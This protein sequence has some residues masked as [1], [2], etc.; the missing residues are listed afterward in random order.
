MSKR[1]KVRPPTKTL[2]EAMRDG[3]TPPPLRGPLARIV[4]PATTA[5]VL[6]GAPTYTIGVVR[7]RERRWYFYGLCVRC[8]R[9]PH[10]P[11]RVDVIALARDR[12]M[13]QSKV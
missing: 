3:D 4:T 9:D 12:E 11:D 6:C 1:R 8:S 5:C 2:A 13:E 10:S 7:L